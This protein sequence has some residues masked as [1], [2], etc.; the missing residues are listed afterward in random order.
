M[1]TATYEPYGAS[2]IV[3]LSGPADELAR[4]VNTL[5]NWGFFSE[6]PDDYR[7]GEDTSV[8]IPMVKESV[9]RATRAI[10]QAEMADTPDLCQAFKHTP[11]GFDCVTDQVAQAVFHRDFTRAKLSEL[12]DEQ[13][14]DLPDYQIPAR[15]NSATLQGAKRRVMDLF[16]RA[17]AGRQDAPH[18]MNREGRE[19]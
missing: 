16:Q 10:A 14:A 18:V 6:P 9:M 12:A 17:R 3:T 4:R 19:V 8:I 15:D 7:E 13:S 2:L 5:C 11:G 1:V